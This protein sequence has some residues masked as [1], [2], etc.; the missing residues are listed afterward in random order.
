MTIVLQLRI[1][2]VFCF[3]APGVLRGEQCRWRPGR[4]R[5]WPGKGSFGAEGAAGP[6]FGR[7]ELQETGAAYLRAA[8]WRR[9][10]DRVAAG[11]AGGSSATVS[12][13]IAAGRSRWEAGRLMHGV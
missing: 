11:R 4:V 5:C 2:G 7:W 13:A 12:H 6:L 10:Q 3:S 8:F 9:T 1:E